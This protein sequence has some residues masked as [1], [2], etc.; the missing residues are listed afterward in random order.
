MDENLITALEREKVVTATFRRLGAAKKLKLYTA[1]LGAFAAEGF[2][3]VSLDVV[4]KKAG[5]SKG[6][7]IQYFT[8]KENLFH[9]TA[10]MTADAFRDFSDKYFRKE[11]EARC[12]PRLLGYLMAQYDFWMEREERLKFYLRFF[13]SYNTIVS[14]GAVSS[15]V[16]QM[17]GN[18]EAIISDGINTGEIRRDVTIERIM[19][20]VLALQEGIMR[21]VSYDLAG[22]DREALYNSCRR[23]IELLFDGFGGERKI[24]TIS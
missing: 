6:S 4:A 24:R 2:D 22:F 18:V 12:R 11:S 23:I 17:R 13:Q 10:A 16:E 7:L 14:E 1:A 15:L 19:L 9:F 3:R 8:V 21:E 20:M 5:V